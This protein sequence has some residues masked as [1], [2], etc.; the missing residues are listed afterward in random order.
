MD[1]RHRGFFFDVIGGDGIMKW[2]I[3]T[4]A[5]VRLVSTR[6]GDKKAATSAGR[7]GSSAQSENWIESDCRGSTAREQSNRTPRS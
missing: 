2:S 7:E 6:L 1:E 3:A 4:P 5:D